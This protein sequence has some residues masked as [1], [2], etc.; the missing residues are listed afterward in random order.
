MCNEGK[1]AVLGHGLDAVKAEAG[2]LSRARVRCGDKA[3]S[4]MLAGQHGVGHEHEEK[5]GWG[6]AG[7]ATSRP[8]SGRGWAGLGLG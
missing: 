8:G 6:G 1:R 2:P 5:E 7:W 3:R 4:G